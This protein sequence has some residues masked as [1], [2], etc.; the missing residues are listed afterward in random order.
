[1][2]ELRNKIKL[3]YNGFW[4][5]T[6]TSL[7]IALNWYIVKYDSASLIFWC[8]ALSIIWRNRN[9]YSFDSNI[10]STI[11]GLLLITWVLLRC[12]LLSNEYSDI[13][14]RIYP[15]VSVFGICFL[16][17][18]ITKV[19]QYWRTILIVSLTGIPFEHIFKLL[20]PTQTISILDAKI[21]RLILWYLGFDVTQTDNFVF[22]PTGSIE[23]AGRC[24]SFNLLWLMWQFCLVIYLCFTLK[25]SQRI[26][27]G[28]WATVI[29]L[30]VN[31]I[32]LC[33]MALLVANNHQ[34]AFEYWHGSS[35]AEVFTTIAILL[36]ALVHWLLSRQKQQQKEDLSKLYES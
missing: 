26:L 12:I 5:L 30:V 2:I 9:N 24:S 20:S 1:M 34:E 16:A 18:K 23:I 7:L 19:T 10:F 31:G 4:L 6:I 14:T 25:K 3:Q 33:L 17:T 29:A 8:A 36:F 11:I 15:L 21:S 13:L 27:L 28:F 35:G 32:R 22:L